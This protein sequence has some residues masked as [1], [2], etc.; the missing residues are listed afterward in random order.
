MLANVLCLCRCGIHQVAK[1]NGT[2]LSMIRGWSV[3]L[4]AVVGASCSKAD[5]ANM[6]LTLCNPRKVPND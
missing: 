1:S 6:V 3:S 2:P 4:Q 5:F